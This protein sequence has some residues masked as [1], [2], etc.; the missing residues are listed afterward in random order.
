MKSNYFLGVCREHGHKTSLEFINE[1]DMEEVFS[2]LD[3]G[4]VQYVAEVAVTDANLLPF[5]SLPC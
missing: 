1:R 2:A 4:E 3:S 5:L